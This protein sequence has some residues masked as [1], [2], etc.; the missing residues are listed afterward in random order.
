VFAADCALLPKLVQA[1]G[2]N[3][4]VA[5]YSGHPG[6]PVLQM[7]LDEFRG[8]YF[9]ADHTLLYGGEA[10]HSQHADIPT[11]IKT[12]VRPFC[13]EGDPAQYIK[14]SQG[15][16]YHYFDTTTFSPEAAASMKQAISKAL[17]A[18]LLPISNAPK[19]TVHTSWIERERT[20]RIGEIAVEIDFISSVPQLYQHMHPEVRP[21]QLKVFEFGPISD[22]PHDHVFLC[23]DFLKPVVTWLYLRHRSCIPD[24]V[25]DLPGKKVFAFPD[26][27]PDLD[28]PHFYKLDLFVPPKESRKKRRI[29]I[30]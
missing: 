20:S 12:A 7:Y 19:F 13:G 22:F 10:Y 21:E 9:H 11:L 4:F 16:R 25:S 18:Y 5:N 14:S 8:A 3:A 23:D 30:I 17:E 29:S 27:P 26:F 2:R 15:Q 28:S 1:F 6:C 24:W